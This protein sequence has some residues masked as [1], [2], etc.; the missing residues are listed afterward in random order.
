MICEIENRPEVPAMKAKPF[1]LQE[2]S[3][4]VNSPIVTDSYKLPKRGPCIV[5]LADGTFLDLWYDRSI[6]LWVL[7]RKDAQG[8]QL[9]DEASYDHHRSDALHGIKHLMRE[10]LSGEQQLVH[11]TEWSKVGMMPK[12]RPVPCARM[13]R[14]IWTLIQRGEETTPVLPIKPQHNVNAFLEDPMHDWVVRNGELHYAS[15]VAG[16]PV[17]ILLEF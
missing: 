17:W 14:R 1:N 9:D 4:R 6:R 11:L 7:L 5:P 8:I 12:A 16:G 13:P 2:Y 3:A 15:R 10:T